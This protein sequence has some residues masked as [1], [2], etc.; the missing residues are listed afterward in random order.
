LE[1]GRLVG[2]ALVEG[3]VVALIG[4]LGA[5][6]TCFTGGLARGLDVAENTPVVS[7]TYTLINE[8]PGR[9]PLFHMDVYR[10]TDLRELEDLGYEEYQ[11]SGGVVVIEWAEK[12]REALPETTLFVHMR[13]TDENIRELIFEGPAERMKSLEEALK[14]GGWSAWR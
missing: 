3:D 6:K 7:P 11:S 13:Y 10:L 12:I 8:Y 9:I 1:I 4:E 2:T 14:S 5:G